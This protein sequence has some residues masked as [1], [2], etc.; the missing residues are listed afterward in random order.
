[1]NSDTPANSEIPCDIPGAVPATRE[2]SLTR[3]EHLQCRNSLAQSNPETKGPI[4]SITPS[5]R[6]YTVKDKESNAASCSRRLPI[7]CSTRDNIPSVPAEFEDITSTLSRL[8]H[9]PGS[10]RVTQQ[11][12]WIRHQRRLTPWRS[13]HTVSRIHARESQ[14]RG[15]MTPPAQRS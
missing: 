14:R 8:S 1:M 3:C 2:V 11:R 15:V 13:K 10:F 12:S 9:A 7:S 5:R 4:R 6:R